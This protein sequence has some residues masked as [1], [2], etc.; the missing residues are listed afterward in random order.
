MAEKG[1]GVSRAFILD[2]RAKPLAPLCI[3]YG[4]EAYRRETALSFIRKRLIPDGGALELSIANKDARRLSFAVS[5]GELSATGG[6][7]GATF[8]ADGLYKFSPPAVLSL[9]FSGEGGFADILEIINRPGGI[10]T[11]W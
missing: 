4:E 3:F 1:D 11:L 2:L 10:L 7:E 6:I 9:R 8:T 5:G